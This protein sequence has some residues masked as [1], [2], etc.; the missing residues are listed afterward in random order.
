MGQKEDNH[1]KKD[2]KNDDIDDGGNILSKC[3]KLSTIYGF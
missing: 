3:S 2:N 1:D